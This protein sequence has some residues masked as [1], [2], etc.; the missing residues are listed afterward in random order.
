MKLTFWGAARQ[1][2]GSMYLLDIDDYKI[3]VDCGSDMERSK[4]GED[5]AEKINLYGLFPF[6]ASE[7]DL[8]IVT[9]AHIDHTG[10]LPNLLKDGYEGQI[11][12]TSPTFYLSQLLLHDA[13]LLNMKKL[14]RLQGDSRKKQKRRDFSKTIVGELYSE[15]NVV[16]T[17]EQFV[18]IAFNHR[19]KVNKNIYLTFIPAGHLLGAAYVLLEINENGTKKTICFSGDI[20]RKN[21]PLLPDPEQVPQVDYLVCESTYGNRNHTFKG[22]REEGLAEIIKQTCI[23]M[24]GRLII[25]AF[26]VGRTQALLY[27]LNKLYSE[28][29]FPHIRVFAD[30]PMAYQSTKVYQNFS[31]QLNEEAQDFQSKHASLFDFEN[32]I[33]VENLKQSK[34]IKNYTEPCIIISSSGMIQG[35]RVEQHIMDNI[36]N[37]YCTV[38]MVGY[39]S[40]GTLGY[41]LTHGLKVIKTQNGKELAVLANIV[42]IDAFSGH[43]DKDDLTD[44]VKYQDASKLKQLFLIHGEYGSMQDFKLHLENEGY[45][46]VTIPHKGQSFDL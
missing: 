27:I 33:Y 41:E 34:M 39:A 36:Q 15:K 28:K 13:A 20:G 2:T 24:P 38:L 23:D 5:S 16:E 45:Q 40:E 46:N 21:Y 14:K 37:P 22:N 29:G 3:L 43:G 18:T 31:K 17:L 35:G 10:K 11:L 42:N 44:F 32:L 26:S 25:P 12:C 30:S 7:L 6:E 8:V 1:V 4:N 9:H 19:F